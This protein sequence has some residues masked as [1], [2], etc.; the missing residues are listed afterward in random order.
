[1]VLE[2]KNERKRNSLQYRNNQPNVLRTGYVVRSN[3]AKTYV[4][5]NLH[6]YVALQ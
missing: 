5:V 4:Y 6:T 1:M 3:N 2:G